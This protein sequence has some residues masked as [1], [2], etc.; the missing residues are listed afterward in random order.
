VLPEELS[1]AD[2][3]VSSVSTFNAGNLDADPERDLDILGPRIVQRAREFLEETADAA[4][5]EPVQWLGGA[6]LPI[7]SVGCHMI[8]E[9]LLHG[10][11]IARGSDRPWPIPGPYA[12]LVSHGLT[13]A[14][15][16][17]VDPRAFVDQR[18]ATGLS[19]RVD[20]RI[21]G[22]DGVLFDLHDGAIRLEY[23]STGRVDCHVS[24]DP[25]ANFHMGW[26]RLT[27]LRAMATGKLVVWGR[28][29]WKAGK[30]TGALR[31]P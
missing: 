21:R 12:A 16:D 6:K 7:R 11:D 26:G 18:K 2:R 20:M 3:L 15:L 8:G 4:G 31:T 29:P 22:T 9:A 14:L 25:V 24:I 17:S 27:P 5:D 30:L 19:A 10:L 1:V 13:L 28:R 23:P